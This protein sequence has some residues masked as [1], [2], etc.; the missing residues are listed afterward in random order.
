VDLGDESTGQGSG[1]PTPSKRTIGEIRRGI[2]VIGRSLASAQALRWVSSAGSARLWLA[3]GGDD[4][5]AC[6][7]SKSCAGS[8][9]TRTTPRSSRRHR[10]SRRIAFVVRRPRPHTP[11]L[12]AGRHRA[13]RPRARRPCHG[14]GPHQSAYLHQAPPRPQ[15]RRSHCSQ[16]FFQLGWRPADGGKACG[17]G[18]PMT[19]ATRLA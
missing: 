5:A 8:C 16:I 17:C 4:P 1:T 9:S 12:S 2:K 6:L 11:A 15:D 7:C 19:H 14:R 3:R 18:L 13:N 10:H